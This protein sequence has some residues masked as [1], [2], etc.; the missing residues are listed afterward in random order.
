MRQIILSTILSIILT[1]AF[2]F[3]KD[4]YTGDC[5][6]CHSLSIKEAGELV[7]GLSVKV[8]SVAMSPMHGFFEVSAE[9][10]GKEGLIFIDFGKKYLMQ[11]AMVK[12]S[13]LKSSK[14]VRSEQVDVTK[15]MRL[16]AVRMGNANASKQI[17]VFSDPD[18]PFC[19][20]MHKELQ[21]LVAENDVA[22]YIKPYPLAIHPEAFKKA[23]TILESGSLDYLNMAFT[24]EDIPEPKDSNNKSAVEEIIGLAKT[25]GIKGTPA[26]LLPDG[27]IE[28][29][30]RSAE[31]I[32]KLLKL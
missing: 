25:L 9:R 5:A 26:I 4:T 20:Q 16:N 30:F 13:D 19:R 2:S 8:K 10:D 28:T 11:G 24:G 21:K 22:V 14:P 7:S 31:A 17:F 18:C 15:L 32:K 23:Q 1:P 29:G 3:S 6:S 27:R 12:I